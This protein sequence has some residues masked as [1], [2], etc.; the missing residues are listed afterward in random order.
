M[1]SNTFCVAPWAMTVVRPSG[2]LVPCCVWKGKFD[3]KFFEYDDWIN[4][5]YMKSVRQS[6][7]RGEK[8]SACQTCWND[9]DSGKVSQ[10]K[11]FERDFYSEVQKYK[12]ATNCEVDAPSVGIDLKLGNLCNLKCVMCFPNSSSQIMTEYKEHIDKFESMNYYEI[13]PDLENNFQWPLS[14]EFVDF[15]TKF[16]HS[17]KWIKLTGGEP[18]MIPYVFDILDNIKHPETV[19]IELI[20]NAT[21]INDRLLNSLLKFKKVSLGISLEGV[22]DHNNQVRWLSK[23]T[24][25]EQNVLK[26]RDLRKKRAGI[27]VGLLHVFQC[28]SIK[29]LIPL[30]QWC[31]ENL[32]IL[33]LQTLTTPPYLSISSVHPEEI[34]KFRYELKQV[35]FLVNGNVPST[36]LKMID[37]TYNY[38][39]VL[40]QQRNEYLSTLDT[41]RGSNLTDIIKSYEQTTI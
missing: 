27:Y 4:S 14:A 10:R 32:M 20:T 18:T 36:V 7:H 25:V 11:L 37:T 8:I 35:K 22:G 12:S 38:S 1:N 6:L 24:E 30:L 19:S 31:E 41:I 3:K 15:M 40:E 33:N 39:A 21:K 16:N 2:A 26:L 28:F 9:E 23:W 5:D 29:T 13:R 17:I 34:E